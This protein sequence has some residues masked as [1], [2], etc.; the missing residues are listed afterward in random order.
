MQRDNRIDAAATEALASDSKVGLLATVDPG[1]LP[2]ISLITSLAARGDDGLTWGQFC[3]G[4]S[5]RN[6]RADP[7]TAFLVLTADKRLWRGRALWT[8]A[9]RE[10]PEYEMY[11]RKPLFRYNTYFGI[12]TVHYMDLVGITAMER[13]R[14]PAIVAGSVIARAA[15]LA[16][17]RRGATEAL[18]PWAF[19]LVSRLDSVKFLSWIDAEGCPTL[20]PAVPCSPADPSRL[21]VAATVYADELSRVP[22]GAPVA[23]F[24]MNLKLQSVLCRGRMGAFRGLPGAEVAAIDV[25]WVYNSM[26]PKQGVVFPE[27]PLA[28][29]TAF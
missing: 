15:S 1:G 2:H 5:K 19:D 18:R 17:R 21:V 7:R 3:E 14:M 6:V 25:D 8:R 27:P 24:V 13:L 22:E 9:S 16:A 29:V 12:H 11:N 4:A 28:A 10:G 26:P 20:V 23:V